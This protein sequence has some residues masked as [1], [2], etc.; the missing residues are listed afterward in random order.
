MILKKIGKAL[1][2]DELGCEDVL[3]CVLG[4][5]S[6]D[7]YVFSAIK[8]K[9]TVKG[10]MDELGKSQTRVQISL[11]NLVSL[12]LLERRPLDTERG[13]KYGYSPVSKEKVK[14]ILLKRLKDSCEKLRKEIESL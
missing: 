10:L 12:G 14:A 13:V 6:T 5:S 4:I 11:N 8:G 9:A 7:A 2:K 3:C 1:D